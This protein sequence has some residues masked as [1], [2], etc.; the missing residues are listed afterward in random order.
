[1]LVLGKDAIARFRADCRHPA[2]C[3][4]INAFLC[5]LKHRQWT[6]TSALQE[7]YPRV[8]LSQ[9]PKVSFHLA[10]NNI[11]IASIVHFDSGVMLLESCTKLSA[12]HPNTQDGADWEAAE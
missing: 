2:Y 7:D 9:M 11:R 8:D 4:E 6:D 12:R 5:D 1:M 10:N 3:D